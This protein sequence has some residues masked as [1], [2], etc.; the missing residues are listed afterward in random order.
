MAKKR[1][2]SGPPFIQLFRF[3]KRSQAYFDLSVHARCALIELIDRYNGI[4][5][6]MIG[7]GVRELAKAL[8]CSQGRASQALRELDDA[9]IARPITGGLWRG[10]RATE[11]QLTFHRCDKTNAL[12]NKSWP[13][14][15]EFTS[16][17]T[18]VHQQEHKATE[19]SL[20]EAHEPKTSMSR[21][22][23]CSSGDTHIDICHRERVSGTSMPQDRRRPGVAA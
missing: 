10:K 5:N 4:N 9:G 22:T 15:R 8:K 17:S 23:K 11:W 2:K 14:R 18:K 13:A 19:C 7:L 1:K 20:A 3:I 12:P 21:L 16:A 6:G